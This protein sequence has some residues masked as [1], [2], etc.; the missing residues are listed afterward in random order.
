MFTTSGSR[1]YK[2]ELY[3]WDILFA[4]NKSRGEKLTLMDMKSCLQT[5]KKKRF[6]NEHL[7]VGRPVYKQKNHVAKGGY[8]H[9]GYPVY[10]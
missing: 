3:G 2:D 5:M 7:L 1:G 4:N 8:L 9:I 10:K 6:K